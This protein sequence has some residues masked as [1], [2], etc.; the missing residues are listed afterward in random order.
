MIANYEHYQLHWDFFKSV[1]PKAQELFFIDLQIRENEERIENGI[2]NIDFSNDDNQ[3]IEGYLNDCERKDFYF[4]V[5]YLEL[6]KTRK[7]DLL[8]LKN[9]E[10]LELDKVF[11][12]HYQCENF[13]EGEQITA[14]CIYS[15]GKA[16]EYSGNEI[17]NIKEYALKVHDLLNEGLFLVHWNQDRPNYGIDHINKRYKDLTGDDLELEYKNEINLAEY[18]ISKFGQ[19]YISHPRLDNLAKLNEFYGIREKEIGDR[20]FATNRILLLTKIYFNALHNSLK[21]EMLNSENKPHPKETEIKHPFSS[22]TNFKLFKYLDEWFKPKAEKSKYT[23][24][25]NHF[26]D[27]DLEPILSQKVYFKFV[28]DFKNISIAQ[29]LQ[30]AP[31]NKIDAEIN[32]LVSK[33]KNLNS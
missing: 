1:N 13:N 17:E 3:T 7:T 15:N 28:G 10:L 33:F 25:Y 14:L 16:K 18:L 24:I 27:N 6:L 8:K 32:R 2:K 9:N 22:E 4:Y 20:T 31:S 5:E 23:Y 26:K 11:F 19:N 30:G 29:R 21:T 12:V